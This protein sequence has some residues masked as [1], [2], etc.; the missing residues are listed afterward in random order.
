MKTANTMVG[1]VIITVEK[2]KEKTSVHLDVQMAGSEMAYAMTP[3]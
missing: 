1:I 2:E 3:V